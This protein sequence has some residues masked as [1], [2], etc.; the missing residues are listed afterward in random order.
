LTLRH[1]PL[2]KI[3]NCNGPCRR[4]APPQRS[5]R[6]LDIREPASQDDLNAAPYAGAQSVPSS[7]SASKL[8]S[9]ND[10]SVESFAIAK[11]RAK[12]V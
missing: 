5:S 9:R 12:G 10:P 7:H 8:G 2:A 6:T 4:W 11:S 1:L 3:R